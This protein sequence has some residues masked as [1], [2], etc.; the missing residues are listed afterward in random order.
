M[1]IRVASLWLKE[2]DGEKMFCGNTGPVIIP[3]G[4]RIYIKRNK[5]KENDKHPDYYLE[6]VESKS[7]DKEKT[8]K[9]PPDD[10][11]PEVPF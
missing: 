2:Y 10:G 11:F 8:E 1:A 5:Q 7:S 9:K 4:A 3:A 6:V